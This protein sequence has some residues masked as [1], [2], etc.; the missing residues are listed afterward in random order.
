MDKLLLDPGKYGC[1]NIH[2]CYSIDYYYPVANSAD[3]SSTGNPKPE[4]KVDYP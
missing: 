3:F 4:T 2:G 1:V